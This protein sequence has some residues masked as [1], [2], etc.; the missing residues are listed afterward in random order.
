[1][2]TITV[3][4]VALK[5]VFIIRN[6]KGIVVR[7]LVVIESFSLIIRSI[8]RL[9]IQ[10]FERTNIRRLTCSGGLSTI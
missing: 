6:D 1:M 7:L 9:I 3:H 2:Y 4:T 8:F 10:V 5:D